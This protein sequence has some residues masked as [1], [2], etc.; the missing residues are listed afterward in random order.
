MELTPGMLEEMLAHSAGYP[1]GQGADEDQTERSK[2]TEESG[3]LD[4]QSLV[5]GMRSFVDKV[6][7]HT[8]AEFP[9]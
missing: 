5:F 1:S 7:S 2:V 8:G 6:S 3:E 4:L 9:W